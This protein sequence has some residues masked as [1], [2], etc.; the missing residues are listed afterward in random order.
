MQM[1]LASKALHAAMDFEGVGTKAILA[2]RAELQFPI[3][4]EQYE[5]AL[6]TAR[7]K[8]KAQCDKLTA[9]LLQGLQVEPCLRASE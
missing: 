4:T 5:A 9:D 7:D 6:S 1:Q 3:D 8:A 2:M